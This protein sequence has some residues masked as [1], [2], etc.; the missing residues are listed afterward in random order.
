ML[1][2]P[3]AMLIV[4]DSNNFYYSTP[5]ISELFDGLYALFLPIPFH[6]LIIR[7]ISTP[8]NV[9]KKCREVH[10]RH[11]FRINS[12]FFSVLPS[13]INADSFDTETP[14]SVLCLPLLSPH[15][16]VLLGENNHETDIFQ[17][18]GKIPENIPANFL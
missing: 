3:A 15:I 11:F 16:Q 1:Q 7:I 13:H 6:I 8:K 5:F 17:N 2:F 18:M 12:N 9:K 10:S 14:I 4:S